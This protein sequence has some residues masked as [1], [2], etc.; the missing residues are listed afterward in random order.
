M[1]D[2]AYAD[3]SNINL[4]LRFVGFLIEQQNFSKVASH[5]DFIKSLNLSHQQRLQ[6]NIYQAFVKEYQNEYSQVLDI[7]NESDSIAQIINDL[8]TISNIKH[9]TGT[10]KLNLGQYDEASVNLKEAERIRESLLIDDPENKT[11]KL[12]LST[13]YAN[14][15]RINEAIKNYKGAIDYYTKAINIQKDLHE[16]DHML[17]GRRLANTY[18]SL[19]AMNHDIHDF[20]E[21]EKYYLNAIEILA[22]LYKFNPNQHALTYANSLNNYASLLTDEKK[23]QESESYF[24]KSFEVY[25]ALNDIAPLLILKPLAMAKVNYANVCVN[26]NRLNQATEELDNALSLFE[27]LSL[28]EERPFPTEVSTICSNYAII[29]IDMGRIEEAEGKYLK[30]YESI[31]S[32]DGDLAF[33]VTKGRTF[34]NIGNFYSIYKSDQPKA[35]NYFNESIDYFAKYSKGVPQ[36]NYFISMAY[37]GM[38][39]SFLFSGENENALNSID[40]AI[41]LTPTDMNLHDTKCEILHKIGKT[42]EAK[43]YLNKIKESNPDIDVTLLPSYNLIYGAS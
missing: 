5:I 22:D 14:L 30:A 24:Y 35:R 15:A 37:N 36:L 26:T 17:F 43:E 11:L 19:A 16:N 42:S 38:A 6:F 21:A 41:K 29:L 8:Y 4:M 40:E 13:T 10:L 32:F 33:T 34:I 2:I 23:Y 9:N 39:Y 1:H 31:K 18:N 20:A 25:E 28:M 7:Y 27:K 12:E 3:T